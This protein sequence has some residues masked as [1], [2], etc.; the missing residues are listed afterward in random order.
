MI[1][2]FFIILICS[3]NNAHW[4]QKNLD[5]V[6]NQTYTNYQV[7]YI[8]D[9]SP[10]NTAQLVQDYIQDN[11]L[12]TK[13]KLIKNK[14]RCYKPANLY[15]AI[16]GYCQDTAIIVELDGDDWLLHPNVLEYLNTLYN[17]YPIWMTYGGLIMQPKVFN[18]L[19]PQPIP[20]QVIKTNSFRS[21]FKTGKIFL[22][23]RSFYAKLFKK[24]KR[25]IYCI[26]AHFLVALLILLL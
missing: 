5:S 23:L 24:I 13:F 19:W 12:E 16:H 4:Y 8:D 6:K 3:Y 2:H 10:D 21:Y 25:K 14:E 17:Q 18:Y 20:E 26:M 1:E 7:I 11:K 22:A 9:A 15:H